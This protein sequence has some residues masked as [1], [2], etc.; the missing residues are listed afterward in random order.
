MRSRIVIIAVVAALLLTGLT[1]PRTAE[2]GGGFCHTVRPGE[3]VSSIA[4]KYGVTVQAIVQANH[5][6]NPNLIYVGQCLIIPTAA[7]K[8]PAGKVCK[9][10]YVVKPGD[11]LKQIAARYGVSWQVIAQLNGLTNPN[12]IYPGQKLV[13]PVKCQPKPPAPGPWTA[14]YWTNPYLSGNPKLTNHPSSVNF[15]WGTKGPGGGVPGT[16]FSARFTRDQ[17]FESGKYIFRIRVDDGVR[18]WLDNILLIDQWKVQAATDYSIERQLS[19]GVHHIQ[20]DYYQAAGQALITATSEKVNGAPSW[21]CEFF[22][23]TNLQGAPVTTQYYGALSFY[24]GNKAPVAGV[25]ADYFSVRCTAQYSFVG[26]TYQFQATVDDGVK[27]YVDD[28]LIIDQWHLTSPVTYTADRDL[29][30]GTHAVKV[31]FFENNGNAVL[32]VVWTQR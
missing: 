30:A 22:N 18:F 5:L 32:K 12:Y 17:T 25:T 6:S 16:N 24:W 21:A 7:P 29:S 3:T 19:A 14:Q 10:T 26:G 9:T 13:I 27:L 31:E 20:I 11:Y 1:L 8:P 4:A 28:A 23:N 2:A 15:N